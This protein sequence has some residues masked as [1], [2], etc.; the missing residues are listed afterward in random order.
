M[1][2][3]VL[4]KTI[5]T[6]PR[7]PPSFEV[8]FEICLYIFNSARFLAFFWDGKMMKPAVALRLA[9]ES[10]QRL[11]LVTSGHPAHQSPTA[12]MYVTILGR[13]GMET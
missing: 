2:V 12:R 7:W 4:F 9:G 6:E 8:H 3:L 11:A 13:L 10:R 1:A 5:S